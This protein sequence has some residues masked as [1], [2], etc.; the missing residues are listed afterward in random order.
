MATVC[1]QVVLDNLQ[2][3]FGYTNISDLLMKK[4]SVWDKKFGKISDTFV[5]EVLD[6]NTCISEALDFYWGKLYKITRTFTNRKGQTFV[7]SDDMFREIIK[8]R[9][10]GSRWDGTLAS[11]NEFFSE[12][13]K[14]R[15][16]IGITDS[17]S[18]SGGL[19]YEFGTLTD[20]EIF[21]FTEKDILPRQ[22]GV[23][24]EVHIIDINTTFGFY[25]TELQPLGQG[26]FYE[27][28]I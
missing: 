2:R 3:Q 8:I 6:F 24:L 17:Q 9:A 27:G 12:L 22:A 19:K 5:S 10:F 13:F 14:D 18:M 1:E 11:A 7:L 16:F 4:A 21:L 25:G 23:E 28:A 15:G 26:V 20:E